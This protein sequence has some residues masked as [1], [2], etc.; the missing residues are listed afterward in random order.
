MPE[1]REDR[2]SG[3]QVADGIFSLFESEDQFKCLALAAGTL[4][5]SC[6][7]FLPILVSATALSYMVHQLQTDRGEPVNEDLFKTARQL[8][9]S[10]CMQ[11]V[12]E[13]KMSEG[14]HDQDMPVCRS[15]SF[16][17]STRARAEVQ[18]RQ[19]KHLACTQDIHLSDLET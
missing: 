11:D 5:R 19:H 10:Q 16:F 18:Q 2:P 12:V 8:N 15:S 14:L 6:D 17:E 4:F 3:L 1:I 7:G 13:S 9:K